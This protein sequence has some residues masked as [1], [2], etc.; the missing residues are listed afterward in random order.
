MKIKWKWN[1]EYFILMFINYELFIIMQ[2]IRKK[3]KYK[4]VIMYM[5]R[6]IKN[7]NV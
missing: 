7:I 3:I 2:K 1:I 5:F 4:F 6:R